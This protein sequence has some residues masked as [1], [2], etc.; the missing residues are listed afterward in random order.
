MKDLEDTDLQSP[1]TSLN[2]L[3]PAVIV[4]TSV[5]ALVST[6]FLINSG[7]DAT[8]KMWGFFGITA[9]FLIV[10]AMLHFWVSRKNLISAVEDPNSTVEG[11]RQ[12]QA[13]EDAHEF[14]AGS[15]NSPD[16]FR[17][18]TSRVREIIAFR[19]ATLYIFD[20]GGMCFRATESEGPDAEHRRDRVADLTD[21]T[22]ARSYF[23]QVVEIDHATTSSRPA[24]AI[25]LKNGPQIFGVLHLDFEMN[26][27]LDELDLDLVDAIG[28]RSAPL[29]LSSI[30]YE[31]SHENA[32]TDS[33]T[34]LPNERAFYLVLENQ[35]AESQRK[36]S[37]RPLTILALDVRSFDE[38]NSRFGHATG[39]RVL[40]FVAQTIK[41]NL[42]QMDFLARAS[43]D[44]FVVVLP[45]ASKEISHDVIA[46]IQTGFFGR[47]L[48]VT[49][50]ESVEIEL[51]IGWAA[52]G[53]DG[54]TPE[55]LLRV[56]RQRK[57]QSKTNAP[58][59]VLWFP[60]EF[61]S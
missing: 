45:T 56:A 18:V 32:L 49:E 20:D 38:I 26:Y 44:E 19:T 51:N 22:I 39:D 36:G 37:S 12:L 60:T 16:S 48:K 21:G 24:V 35:V 41:D 54:E 13:L 30:S 29:V 57:D 15:L 55:T 46:R 6:Y 34:D 2:S 53:T 43:A 5:V 25:P 28:T 1:R 3:Y 42:R 31:Q 10:S 11:D 40:G 50:S 52:F 59:K 47:K 7:L 27:D 8:V 58:N 33:T 9:G 23:S 14:F 17:L 4:V 61:A